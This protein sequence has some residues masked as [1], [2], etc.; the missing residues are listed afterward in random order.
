MILRLLREDRLVPLDPNMETM[1]LPDAAR[2]TRE[3]TPDKDAPVFDPVS[4]IESLDSTAPDYPEQVE[5]LF[6]KPATPQSIV[7]PGQLLT[8]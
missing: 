6:A 4:A 2:G 3:R 1:P 5:R 7:D 8:C